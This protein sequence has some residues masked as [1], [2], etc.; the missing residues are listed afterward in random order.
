MGRRAD[1]G[2]YS[3]SSLAVPAFRARARAR[4]PR[5]SSQESEFSSQEYERRDFSNVFDNHLSGE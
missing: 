1:P 5:K 4:N 3:T 2:R